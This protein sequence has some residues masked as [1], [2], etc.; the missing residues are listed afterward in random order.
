MVLHL[1]S[2][3]DDI[4][5]LKENVEHL[6]DAKHWFIQTDSD[7]NGQTSDENKNKPNGKESLLKIG[8]GE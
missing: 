5:I 8:M 6:I 2:S 4:S 7:A 3:I 1:H